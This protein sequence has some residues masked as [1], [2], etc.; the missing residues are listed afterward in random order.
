MT[1]I[2]T[3]EYARQV[4]RYLRHIA[5]LFFESC[6]RNKPG[7]GYPMIEVFNRGF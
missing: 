3:S 7:I 4:C 2:L 6:D 1:I 5:Q